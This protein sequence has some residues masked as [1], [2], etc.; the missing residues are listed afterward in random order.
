MKGNGMAEVEIERLLAQAR[1]TATQPSDGFLSRV[2]ADAY[3]EQPHPAAAAA[4]PT[5]RRRVSFWS[6]LV[7]GLGGN[8]VLASVGSAACLGLYIGYADPSGLSDFTDN[9]MVTAEPGLEFMP[10]AELFLTEG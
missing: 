4:A 9:Y 10:A 3:A 2:L 6:G 8:A 5:K 7:A 1:T